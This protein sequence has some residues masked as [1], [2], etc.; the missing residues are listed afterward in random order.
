MNNSLGQGLDQPCDYAKLATQQGRTHGPAVM[1]RR[2]YNIC[3]LCA[4]AM[5][6]AE[7]QEGELY[8]ALNEKY[9]IDERSKELQ[10]RCFL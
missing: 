8:K 5:D 7:R 4:D 2:G 10:R 9:V 3:Q 1:N 6:E